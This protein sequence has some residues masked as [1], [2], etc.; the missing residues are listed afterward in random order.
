MVD[1]YAGYVEEGSA[2]V[3][4]ADPDPI[5]IHSHFYFCNYYDEVVLKGSAG[6]VAVDPETMYC[7]VFI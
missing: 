6:F 1:V 5:Y 4:I 7:I 2:G 3:I